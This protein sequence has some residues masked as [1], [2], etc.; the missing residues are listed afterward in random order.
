MKRNSGR[1]AAQCRCLKERHRQTGEKGQDIEREGVG[2]RGR[3]TG[4]GRLRQQEAEGKSEG[5]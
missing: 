5:L 1:T 2:L 4:R 3:E